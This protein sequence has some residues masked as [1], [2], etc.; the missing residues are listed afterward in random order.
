MDPHLK[1]FVDE[2]QFS[3]E[4]EWGLPT[5]NPDAAYKSLAKY[6]KDIL[7][8]ENAQVQAMNLATQWTERH[9]GLY[10]QNSKVLG[11]QEAKEHLD[12]STSTGAPFNQVFKTK[13]ELFAGDPEIDAWLEKDWETMA[14]DPN[15][16]CLFTNSLKEELRTAEKMADNSIRTFLSGGVDAVVH[17]TRLFVDMNE[18]MYAS[19][20]KSASAVGM[21]PYKGNWNILYNKLKVFKKGY[22]LDE[23]QYD[24]SLRAF[25]MWNCARMR[26]N[27]LRQEDRTPQNLIRIQ[28]YYRN[29]INTLIICPDGTIVMKKGGNPSG[30]VNT[31]TD[32]TLI[33][34]TLKAYAW[35]VNAPKDM[36]D[37]TSFEMHVA[38]CLVGDDNTWSVSDEAHPFYNAYTVIDA[39]KTLG[40]TTTT[41]SMEP[42]HPAELDFLSA[43]TIFINGVAVPVYDR[44]KMMTTLLYAPKEHHTPATTLER[45]AALLS[46][47]WTDIPFRKFCREVIAWLLDHF[48]EVLSDEPRWIMAKCQIQ[49]DEKY[50]K[51]FLGEYT[52]LHKQSF[53]GA[54]VK[55]IQPE[56]NAMSSVKPKGRGRKPRSKNQSGK[57]KTVSVNIN[58]KTGSV[59][60]SRG[61]KN[62]M[63]RRRRGPRNGQGRRKQ[64]STRGTRNINSNRLTC[65]VSQSEYLGEVNGSVGFV[66]TQYPINPGISQTFPWLSKQAIQ[67]EKYR[68]THLEFFYK[69]EVSEYA[70]N[71]QTGKV[72]MNVDFDA[73]DAPPASKRQME[74]SQPSRDCMP[75]QNMTMPLNTRQMHGLYPELFVRAGPIVVAADIKTYD[76]GTFNIA[77]QGNATTDVVGE[78]H[79]RYTVVFSVPVLESTELAPPIRT[80]SQFNRIRSEAQPI[81]R[82]GSEIVAWPD[83]YADALQFIQSS[84][85]VFTIPTAGNYLVDV[86]LA[87]A[88]TGNN[89][90]KWFL[91]ASLN[92]DDIGTGV[93]VAADVPLL[94]S[95][96][97]CILS[98]AYMIHAP[99][100]SVF[101][102]NAA[103]A[104]TSGA[105][106]PSVY[107]QV[108]FVA[109]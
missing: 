97:E 45:T 85:G 37:Y 58:T 73:S 55:L 91:T 41:D 40:V 94:A 69:K 30:S 43:H 52:T 95:G 27:M 67:W 42:R 74:D 96:G 26:W 65:T 66:N 80:V 98:S 88:I 22:A 49:T 6:A 36:C 7:P 11:Y 18:K 59:T 99:A 50:Q 70:A 93:E 12:M 25:L 32:N 3:I 108:R 105:G 31:I 107:G 92:G 75:S 62:Q 104:N 44:T 21:S 77:T 53:S 102:V 29:L 79:V 1:C 64:N 28:I 106:Q 15:W 89:D 84:G 56:K 4:P 47:G 34:Y 23:S 61:R 68:F 60:E 100:G 78:L 57:P 82:N 20:L 38:K 54:R 17:G 35:I 109:V 46:V 39:W 48:D 10:M 76:V 81:G 5:P 87:G 16:T 19:H 24:S 2:T 103:N 51:L 83:T 71:G 63:R 14:T 8:L 13:K 86:T 72:I 9:F 101:Q 33:L 90:C